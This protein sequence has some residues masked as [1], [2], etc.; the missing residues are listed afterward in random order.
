RLVSGRWIDRAVGPVN[1]TSGR[2][3]IAIT[4]S[5]HGTYTL[6]VRSNG[7]SVV[8][9]QVQ[10]VVKPRPTTITASLSATSVQVGTALQVRGTVI[11]RD[12][13]SRVVVQRQVGGGWSDRQA[14]AVDQRTGRFAITITPSEAGTY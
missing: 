12:A 1:Q 7:G 8:S 13:L 6:R 10:L 9:P 5:E 3:R 11:E 4:P 14:G 2:Y